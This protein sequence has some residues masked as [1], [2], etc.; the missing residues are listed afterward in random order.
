MSTQLSKQTTREWLQSEKLKSQI[1]QALPKGKEVD[2]FM[3]CLYTAVQKVPKLQACSQESLFSTMIASAQLGIEPDGRLAH[4]IPYGQTATLIIDY[5]GLVELAYRTNNVSNIHA[6][7]VCEHDDFEFNL[8]QVEKHKIDLRKPRGDMYAVYV[9]VTL[10]D[11]SKK[12]EVMSKEEVDKIKNRS[13][14]GNSGPWVSDFNEMAK[15][16]VF[17]RSSK[18]LQLSPEVRDAIQHDD[19]EY[20]AAEP[21]IDVTNTEL[22]DELPGLSTT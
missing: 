1:G 14:S 4:L 7:V 18:W 8:G 16:T 19:K 20:K 10:K 21:V 6:D 22:P 15:K 12:C 2:R 9:I 5:K 11:G 17:K 13:K 3:R